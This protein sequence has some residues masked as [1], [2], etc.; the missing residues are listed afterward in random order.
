MERLKPCPKCG[1]VLQPRLMD[2]LIG[3]TWCR[4]LVCAECKAWFDGTS[5]CSWNRR[6]SRNAEPKKRPSDR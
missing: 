5:A 6:P 4:S 3:S 2:C 1:S